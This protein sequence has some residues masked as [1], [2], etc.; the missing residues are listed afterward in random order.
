M[1]RKVVVTLLILPSLLPPGVCV[2]QVERFVLLN[3]DRQG[4]LAPA[5]AASACNCRNPNCRHRRV[6]TS[7]GRFEAPVRK[8]VPERVPENQHAPCCPAHPSYAFTRAA[9]VAPAK[10]FADHLLDGFAWITPFSPSF[11]YLSPVTEPLQ[12]Y[13]PSLFLLCGNLRC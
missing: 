11:D 8:H 5:K 4:E 9:A 1:L 10:A 7:T 2:C 3:A 6:T 13:P 12:A